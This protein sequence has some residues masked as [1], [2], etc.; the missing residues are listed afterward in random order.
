MIILFCS[1]VR[2]QGFTQGMVGLLPLLHSVWSLAGKTW[3]G[4]LNGCGAGTVRSFIQSQVWQVVLAGGWD[5]NVLSAR[6]T[7]GRSQA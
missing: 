2:G 3:L 4:T 1:Q 7:R 6:S 5:L